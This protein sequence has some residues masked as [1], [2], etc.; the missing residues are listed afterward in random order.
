M[1]VEVRPLPRV[2]WHGKKDKETFAVPKVIEA[3]YDSE[4]GKYATG[5]TDEE[6]AKYGKLLGVDLNPNYDYTVPHPF[7]SSKT[8][9]VTLPNNTQ[10]FDTEKHIEY[11]KIK[12]M[13][14]HKW[15]ANSYQE[16]L[17][18][19]WPEA[20]H[21][22]FDENEQIDQK[23]T[24]AQ[25]REKAY[26]YLG[27]MSADDKINIIQIITNKSLKGRKNNFIDAEIDDILSNKPEEFI[28]NVEMGKEEVQTRATVLEL[29][30]KGILTKDGNAIY[31]M[32]ELL[33]VD[34]EEVI[35]Y[36]K[37]PNNQRMKVSIMEK[38]QPSVTA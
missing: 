9:W 17:D 2:Q 36:F 35:K 18:G 10:F 19:K 24:K 15:V 5:L 21:Y 11:V 31:Y 3:L 29:I 30:G 27:K 12:L 13:K 20:T 8:A 1:K 16:W 38:L 6:A 34:Y 26:G 37:N 33:G 32:G 25:Q 22:I 23:A 14:A 28:R 4:T 7:Y